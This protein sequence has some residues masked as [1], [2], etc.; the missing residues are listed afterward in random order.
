M[1]TNDTLDIATIDKS[2]LPDSGLS[3]DNPEHDELLCELEESLESYEQYIPGLAGT[4][5]DLCYRSGPY[6]L[7]YPICIGDRINHSGDHYEI[8]HRLGMGAFSVVW[9][10]RDLKRNESVAF[11]VVV[12]GSDGE[13]EFANQKMLKEARSVEGP[14]LN[15]Y[16]DTFLLESPY[17]EARKDGTPAMFHRVLV[18]PLAGPPLNSSEIRFE[19]SLRSRMTAAKS[20]LEALRDLHKAGFVHGGLCALPQLTCKCILVLTNVN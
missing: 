2:N 14:N 11:K 20:L 9:L 18:L 4:G 8:V 12:E 7:A 16:Q 5:I 1:G 13:K 3:E 10:A 15:L 6:G 19:R 17:N